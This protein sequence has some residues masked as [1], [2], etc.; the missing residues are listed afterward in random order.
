MVS[1]IRIGT[2]WSRA[3]LGAAMLA[4]LSLSACGGGGGDSPAVSTPSLDAIPVPRRI[5]VS[6]TS[7]IAGKPVTTPTVAKFGAAAGVMHAADPQ[8]ASDAAAALQ[9]ALSEENV[10]LSVT[11]GTMDAGT[12]HDLVMSDNNGVLVDPGPTGVAPTVWVVENF[13]LDPLTLTDP[14]VEQAALKQF[15]N[16]L[17][18]YTRRNWIA[19]KRTFVVQPPPSCDPAAQKIV[20]QIILTEGEANRQSPISFLY[21]ASAISLM[22]NWQA[23]M[24]VTCTKPGPELTATITTNLAA[25]IQAIFALTVHPLTAAE[26]QAIYGDGSPKP[27]LPAS[28]V[29]AASAPVAASS[30]S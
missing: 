2:R 6:G 9:A 5:E 1:S 3:T 20:D 14:V 8:A 22:P 28:D 26:Y 27:E 23:G 13:T 16:D 10:P 11:I 25:E 17:F 24:D 21:S 30:S 19:G 4:A 29:P 18:I 15:Q 7:D 12:L